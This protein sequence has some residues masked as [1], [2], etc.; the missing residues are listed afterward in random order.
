MITLKVNRVEI[1]DHGD[2]NNTETNRTYMNYEC[3]NVWVDLQ[4]DG[5]TLKIFLNTNTQTKALG[6]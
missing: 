5:Y 4:D 1:I 6:E 3:H 2:H